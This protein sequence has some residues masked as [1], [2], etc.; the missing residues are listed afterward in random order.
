LGIFR[1]LQWKR[2]VYIWSILRTVGI[3]YGHL[4]HFWLFGI[5]FVFLYIFRLF[6][7]FFPV[8]VSITKENLAIWC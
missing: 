4:V 7:I 5:F 3:I 2:L 8:L 6:G 1:G